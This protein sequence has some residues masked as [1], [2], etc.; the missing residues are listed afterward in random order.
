MIFAIM[1]FVLMAS[2]RYYGDTEKSVTPDN[3]E[4]V[5]PPAFFKTNARFNMFK[6]SFFPFGHLYEATDSIVL[7]DYENSCTYTLDDG[8]RF[9][10]PFKGNDKE[11]LRR[12][13]F[14]MLNDNDDYR[15]VL[16]QFRLYNQNYEGFTSIGNLKNHK[17]LR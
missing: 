12:L 8:I 15:M 13:K 4:V 3:T 1:T 6:F 11:L 14:D 17:K 2:A 10:I 5:S 9:V 7:T 16:V